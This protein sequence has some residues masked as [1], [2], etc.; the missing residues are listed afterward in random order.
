MSVL[1][2]CRFPVQR[3][4]SSC[5]DPE[6][7][8]V[9]AICSK[10]AASTVPSFIWT[11][12]RVSHR[13]ESSTTHFSHSCRRDNC[14]EELRNNELSGVSMM[15]LEES[16]EGAVAL[17]TEAA[18]EVEAAVAERERG[19]PSVS[20]ELLLEAI[21]KERASL[22]LLEAGLDTFHRVLDQ[23]RRAIEQQ[24]NLL[25]QLSECFKERR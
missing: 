15:Q 2:N 10:E 3:V 24:Q 17:Q 12:T 7:Q 25:T 22:D 5:L 20:I 1:L 21:D 14:R 13:K 4:A 11:Q 18:E 19:E 9:P 6:H 23:R 8:K 16:L